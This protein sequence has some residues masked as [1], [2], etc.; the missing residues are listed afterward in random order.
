MFK[1]EARRCSSANLRFLV[2]SFDIFTGRLGIPKQN[3]AD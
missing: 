1:F 3:A 2:F